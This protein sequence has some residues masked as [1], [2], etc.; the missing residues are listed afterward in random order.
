VGYVKALHR[1]IAKGREW[2][3]SWPTPP[4]DEVAVKLLK[5]MMQQLRT[6]TDGKDRPAAEAA[7]AEVH[8]AWCQ[9]ER[10]ARENACADDEE[11]EYSATGGAPD[12]AV[13]EVS[14]RHF[15]DACDGTLTGTGAKGAQ[16]SVMSDQPFDPTSMVFRRLDIDGNG[17]ISLADLQAA[18]LDDAPSVWFMHL[19]ESASPKSSKRRHSLRVIAKIAKGLGGSEGSNGSAS[20]AASTRAKSVAASPARAS[21]LSKSVGG[22]PARV[23]T[24]SRAKSVHAD[25]AGG[26]A[27]TKK[28]KV[29]AAASRR[30]SL[31]V[32]A[33][34]FALAAGSGMGGSPRNSS[35]S[36]IS[37]VHP[38]PQGETAQP[39]ISAA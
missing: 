6:I 35:A 19:R 29:G 33:Q 4:G 24:T 23:S 31:K 10:T 38:H 12:P 22:S 37:K 28:N 11:E 39:R 18:V 25:T 36:K 14:Y 17:T 21:T 16:P 8:K 5:N 26:E 9:A 3:H 30:T 27:K 13:K 15:G 1:S 20:L 2:R 7:L 34:T 32:L